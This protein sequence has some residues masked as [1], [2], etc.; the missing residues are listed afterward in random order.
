[1]A[2]GNV[3]HGALSLAG[4]FPLILKFLHYVWIHLIFHFAMGDWIKKKKETKQRIWVNW[5]PLSN[6]MLD[7][8]EN[9]TLLCWLDLSLPP[10]LRSDNMFLWLS[11]TSWLRNKVT[12]NLMV[13]YRSV[14]RSQLSSTATARTRDS[15]G[16]VS[17]LQAMGLFN[18]LVHPDT[19]QLTH[20]E[21]CVKKPVVFENSKVRSIIKKKMTTSPLWN[22]LHT[23]CT[24]ASVSLIPAWSQPQKLRL[25]Y[26][27]KTRRINQED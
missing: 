15:H 26:L 25:I 4:I 1:M 18:M 5:S 24:P 22:A 3:I 9:I 23:F 14:Q 13:S 17:R 6:L 10:S 12:L 7:D 27:L 16:C 20:S 19:S 8:G 2:A 11:E 21:S